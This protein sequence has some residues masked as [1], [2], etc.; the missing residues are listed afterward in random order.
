VPFLQHRSQ[1]PAAVRALLATGFPP[2][3]KVEL[4]FNR[5]HLYLGVIVK[6]SKLM[7]SS[8]L[9]TAAVLGIGA[10]SAAD[11]PMRA[12]PYAAPVQVFS[13]TGC[14]IGVHAGAG[15]MRDSV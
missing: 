7:F 1:I 8:A 12:A 9:A 2:A 6:F 13:W 3:D 5:N 10:A 4:R 14:Y 11:L 15:V